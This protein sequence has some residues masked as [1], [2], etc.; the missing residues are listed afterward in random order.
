MNG[1]MYKFDIVMVISLKDSLLNFYNT[2]ANK[3]IKL[4]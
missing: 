4:F 1:L 3:Q 2:I